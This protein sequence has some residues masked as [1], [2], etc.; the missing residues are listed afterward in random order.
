MDL[1]IVLDLFSSTPH[2]LLVY[3]GILEMVGD[4]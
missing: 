3:L 4:I 1:F 2:P